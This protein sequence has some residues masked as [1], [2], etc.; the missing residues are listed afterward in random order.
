MSDGVAEYVLATNTGST[1]VLSFDHVQ[2][3][4]IP[5]VDDVLVSFS[6]FFRVGW[7]SMETCTYVIQT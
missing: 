1:V 4:S 5:L 3:D 6:F 2:F 7:P